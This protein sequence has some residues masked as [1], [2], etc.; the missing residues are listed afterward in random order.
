M[1]IGDAKINDGSEV[2][3][4]WWQREEKGEID[5]MG[6]GLGEIGLKEGDELQVNN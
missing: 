5:A 6:M 2:C 1:V 3:G 4:L